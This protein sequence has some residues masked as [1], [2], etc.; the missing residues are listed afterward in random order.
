MR[1]GINRLKEFKDRQ[2]ERLPEAVP[3]I[4]H[5]PNTGESTRSYVMVDEK[6][7]VKNNHSV[8]LRY[9]AIP[10]PEQKDISFEIEVAGIDAKINLPKGSWGYCIIAK[11]VSRGENGELTFKREEGYLSRVYVGKEYSKEDI[12]FELARLGPQLSALKRRVSSLEQTKMA[13]ETKGLERLVEVEGG[14][15]IGI[16]D[17]GAKVIQKE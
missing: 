12:D 15:K 2:D 10:V 14:K 16:N 11:Q 1:R 8:V 7:S 3:E 5:V 6:T 4:P 9:Y 17:P 13:M